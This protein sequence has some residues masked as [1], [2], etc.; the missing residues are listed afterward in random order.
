[1]RDAGI[2]PIV[3]HPALKAVVLGWSGIYDEYKTAG[4]TASGKGC[5]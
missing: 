4:A 2:A 1:M 5:A 3:R